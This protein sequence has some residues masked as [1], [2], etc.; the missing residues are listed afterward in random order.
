MVNFNAPPGIICNN[1]SLPFILTMNCIPGGDTLSMSMQMLHTL[2]NVESRRQNSKIWNSKSKVAMLSFMHNITIILIKEQVCSLGGGGFLV[3]SKMENVIVESLHL[4]LLPTQTL[5]IQA[6]TFLCIER[7]AVGS[8]LLWA[9][10]LRL[11]L[12][13][14]S[15]LQSLALLHWCNMNWGQ[16]TCWDHLLDWYR[17]IRHYV[18]AEK[19]IQ[20]RHHQF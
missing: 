1:L 15:S 10:C 18:H 16:M 8:L 9:V 11:S 5:F 7:S 6:Y 14:C 19:L 4:L 2:H 12:I 17:M 3:F 13:R 20:N